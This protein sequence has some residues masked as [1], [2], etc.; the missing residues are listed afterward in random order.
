M[1]ELKYFSRIL[2]DEQKLLSVI[3]KELR[4]VS[5]KLGTDRKTMIEDEIESIKIEK[6]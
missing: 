2:S 6:N 5:A 3:K 1:N 4:S